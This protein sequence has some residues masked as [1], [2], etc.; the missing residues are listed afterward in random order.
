MRTP[1]KTPPTIFACLNDAR[2]V[3]STGDKNASFS[4]DAFMTAATPE[5]KGL[6]DHRMNGR[7][8][9]SGFSKTGPNMRG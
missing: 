2:I 7:A 1:T 3:F 8:H 4:S 6:F 5:A 9:P